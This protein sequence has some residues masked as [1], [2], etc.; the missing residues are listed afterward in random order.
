MHTLARSSRRLLAPVAIAAVGALGGLTAVALAAPG[1]GGRAHSAV[2]SHATVVIRDIDFHRRSVTV[3]R[4][5]TV[6]WRFADPQ[7]SH[8]VTSRGSLRF[9]SSPT[10]LSGAY[11]ATFRRAGTYHY[12]CTIHPNMKGRVVV[13]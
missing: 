6:T 11:T 8:N 1:P 7:V 4:G 3:R 9:R 5:G 12:V 13:R 10:K 2:A